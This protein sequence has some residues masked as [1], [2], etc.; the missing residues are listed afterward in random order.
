[1]KTWIFG[2]KDWSNMQSNELLKKIRDQYLG[3][4]LSLSYKQPLHIV[5]GQGQYL[6][7]A[8][9]KEYLDAVNNIQHVGH[10]HPK[11]VEVATS[12]LQKLNT[13][14]RYLDETILNYAQALADKLPEGL[15]KFFFTNSGSESND[16]AL[17]L[18][19]HYTNSLETIVL[20]GAYHGHLISL[21]EI[22]PYKYNGPGG[23]GKPDHVH[24]VPMPDPFRGKYRGPDSGRSYRDEVKKIIDKIRSSSKNVSA[25][26][27]ESIMGCGGQLIPPSNF[28][29]EAYDLIRGEGG[30]C[31]ADEVQIGLGRMGEHFWGF[32]TQ[33]IV[34]DV[35]TIGKSIGNGHPLS[36]VVTT[37]DVAD[38]FNNGM[39]YFNSF[40][41]NPVSCAI[42]HAVLDIIE[43]E[44]LQKNA[45]KLGNIML[46]MLMELKEKHDL[47]GD[48]R[49]KG[50]FVGIELISD[51]KSLKPAGDMANHIV[52]Q[53][54]DR[55]I[56][57]STDGPDHNVI[58]IKPPMVFNN[59]NALFLIENL[60]DILSRS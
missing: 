52:D 16:L 60:D 49:G 5:S 42:G 9:G 14:T 15:D 58:K 51:L 38:R 7:D 18:A 2:L 22:S 19:R 31:I 1:M 17:R 11:L 32:E 40:G 39:E 43:E 55:G 27:A 46:S 59:D 10:C 13:N 6:Y 25:F 57:L 36:V 54:K 29:K 35:V 53:M 33:A 45:Y 20:D 4:S 28:L 34:P 30:L 23:Q 12:Q 37:K 3:P 26:I 24:A 44:E 56:L 50:L 21:I 47:I 8:D 48:V 41:G